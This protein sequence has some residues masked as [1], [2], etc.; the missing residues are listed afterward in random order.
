M[1]INFKLSNETSNDRDDDP[2]DR[3]RVGYKPTL[4]ASEIFSRNRGMWPL[5]TDRAADEKYATFSYKGNIVA[6]AEISGIETL[7]WPNPRGRRDKKAA[8]GCALEPGHPANEYFIGRVIKG[9]RNPVSYIDDPEPRPKPEPQ[10]C[11]CGCGTQV[12]TSKRFVAGHDQKAVHERIARQW[13][14]AVGFIE[15]F[16]ATYPKRV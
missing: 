12:T 9:D 5:N 11:A 2:M 10:Y 14:G 3:D 4:T 8:I 13:D 6:V 7:P 16:D 1:A 15:W